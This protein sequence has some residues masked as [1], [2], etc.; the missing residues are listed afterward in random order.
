MAGGASDPLPPDQPAPATPGNEA[1]RR[2]SASPRPRRACGWPFPWRF[3][4]AP[5]VSCSAG[6]SGTSSRCVRLTL[7]SSGTSPPFPR[8]SA[9]RLLLYADD[10]MIVAAG[11]PLAQLDPVPFQLEV[12]RRW[13]TCATHRPRYARQP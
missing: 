10:N 7:M 3:S 12:D 1:G 11:A 4:W 6:G 2:P 5:R 9:A 8:M 13:R